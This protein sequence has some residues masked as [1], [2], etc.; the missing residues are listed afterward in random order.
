M[1]SSF[2]TVLEKED[3]EFFHPE[4]SPDEVMEEENIVQ[5]FYKIKFFLVVFCS[6]KIKLF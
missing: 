1:N 6:V 3:R 2:H 5:F 4:N